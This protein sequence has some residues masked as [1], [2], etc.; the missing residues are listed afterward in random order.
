MNVTWWPRAVGQF[1]GLRIALWTIAFCAIASTA[2]AG[3][4]GALVSPGAP[5]KAHA[6]L[7]GATRCTQCH[8]AGRRVPTAKCLGCHAPIASRIAA[9]V[10]VHRSARDCISCHVEHAGANGDLRHIDT[11]AFQHAIETRFPLDGQHAK[12]AANCAAC[13]KTRSFL[14]VQM[15]CSSCHAD[16]HKGALGSTCTA[17]HSTAAP[18]TQARDA[19]D[20]S[21]TMFP[22]TGA[23]Q[24]VRCEQCHKTARFS[25]V[26][27]GSCA[28]CHTD[29]HEKK[30]GA[31]CVSCHTTTER[32][33]TRSVDHAKTGFPLK[34]AH[35]SVACVKCHT[36][37]VMTAPLKADRCSACH[38]NVHRDSIKDDCRTCHTETSFR[39]APFDHESR[40]G[41]PLDGRHAGLACVKCHVGVSTEGLPLARKVA[42]YGG[43]SPDCV[44]CHG[45]TDPHKG[46]FGRVCEACHRTSTFDA[47][48][49]RHPRAAE[50]FAGSHEPVA[51]EQCHVRNA[52]LPALRPDAQAVAAAAPAAQARIAAARFPVPAMTCVSCHDDVHLGQVSSACETCHDVGGARFAAVKFEHGRTPFPLTGR[53][54]DVQCALCHRTETRMFPSGTGTAMVLHPAGGLECRTCHADPHLGQV[55]TACETCHVT[56][57][58][59]VESYIHRGMEDFFGGI[60]GRYDCVDC[61]K[62]ETGTFPAGRGTTT[63]FLVGRTCASCHRGF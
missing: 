4:L 1:R 9:R 22:L 18:F 58:F 63:K 3:Q 2:H 10:G 39:G 61:H 45:S 52:P 17:C 40:T 38:V 34:G 28:S 55:S 54:Q 29:P 32:W 35:A 24:P 5:S 42:D 57:T 20:H 60:H 59:K 13:H 21:K 49:F 56:S 7:S 26:P 43:A 31:N 14:Q 37:G 12:V 11:R 62:V 41:F 30:F 8:E 23:H 44:S 19:F 15:S 27:F 51:C 6:S 16:P 46:A 53:H 48:A 36:S 47:R 25:D 33:S 50:F